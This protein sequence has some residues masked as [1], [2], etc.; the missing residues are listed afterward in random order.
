MAMSPALA[1]AVTSWWEQ[2]RSA[3]SWWLVVCW[4]LCYCVQFSAARWMKSHGA[5][6]WLTQ[7]VAYCVVLC[8]VGLPFVLMH[9]DILVWAPA[10]ALLAAVSFIAAWRREERSLWANAAAVCASCLMAALTFHYGC[11]GAADDIPGMSGKGLLLSCAFGMV[12]FGSVLFVKTMIRERGSKRYLAASWA[13]H[14]GALLLAA[15]EG[16][17]ALVA[18][19]AALLSRAVAVPIVSMRHTVRPLHTGLVEFAASM[20]TF[21]L[22]VVAAI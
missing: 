21:V 6:R 14:V 10:M 11:A 12:Q 9:P 1:G 8:V 18:L 2:G 5:R 16:D 3:A 4:L 15:F 7:P 22:I 17:A 13:W 19:G 20:L